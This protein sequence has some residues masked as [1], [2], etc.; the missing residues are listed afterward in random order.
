MVNSRFIEAERMRERAKAARQLARELRARAD[1]LKADAQRALERFDELDR[2]LV[3]RTMRRADAR[4]KEDST[5]NLAV[6]A[7]HKSLEQLE[8]VRMTPNNDPALN[9][10]KR[11]IRERIRLSWKAP[12]ARR[13]EA[14]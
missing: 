2:A 12:T 11:D 5:R 4:A 3:A 10:L 8:T 6:H 9:Q 13:W 14:N 1:V 7:L